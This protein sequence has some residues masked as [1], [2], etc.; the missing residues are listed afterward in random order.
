MPFARTLTSHPAMTL[1][2][3]GLVIFLGA[4]ATRIVAEPWRGRTIGRLGLP[5]WKA[6]HSLV[7]LAGL[8]LVVWGF[9]AARAQPLALW[10][11]PLWTRHLAALIMLPSLVLF[12]AAYV[13]GNR[14]KARLHHPMLLGVELWAAAHL[15]ANGRLHDA[16]LFGAFLLW[17]LLDH[18]A[19]LARD[20]ATAIAYAPGRWG[21]T[22]LA[23][24]VGAAAWAA[25]AFWGHRLL[26][27]VAPLGV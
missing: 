16:V 11:P 27:G 2:L 26:F 12:V 23:L 7:S 18:R 20:R 1:M 13:P 17:A 8:A 14:L 21:P 5:R 6:L 10:Q 15:L 22:A 9:A 24:A 4:H 25:L 19:A 3:L